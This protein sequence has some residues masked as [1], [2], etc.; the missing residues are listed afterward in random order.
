LEA[1]LIKSQLPLC[2]FGSIADKI[3][4]F[5]DIYARFLLYFS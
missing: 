1:M 5:L 2:L 3:A 4:I